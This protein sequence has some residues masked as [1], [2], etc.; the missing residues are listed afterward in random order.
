[1]LERLFTIGTSLQSSEIQ[2][3]SLPVLSVISWASF[4]S[5]L[6]SAS[7]Q[8]AL[9]RWVNA[10]TSIS[11]S[12][13]LLFRMVQISL[14]ANLE[15]LQTYAL[16][17]SNRKSGLESVDNDMRAFYD[18]PN[19][20]L[21]RH[22]ASRI[23]SNVQKFPLSELEQKMADSYR[24]EPL[25]APHVPYCVYYATLMLWSSSV[26]AGDSALSQSSHLQTG[27]SV[28]ASLKS[29][30]AMVLSNALREVLG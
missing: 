9:D 13:M 8:I 2:D 29:R 6:D 18:S 12:N 5:Q 7:T 21:T 26:I 14:H 15:L 28:L 23:L 20:M 22:H 16:A 3:L 11:S 4:A 27:L 24:E 10:Q 19:G 1:M 30:I 17:K 25:G